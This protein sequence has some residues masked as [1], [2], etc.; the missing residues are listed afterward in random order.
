[1]MFYLRQR[2]KRPPYRLWQIINRSMRS[3][4]D[5]TQLANLEM[6]SYAGWLGV[7]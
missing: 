5:F 1:L 7:V 4:T 6:V 2:Q 3:D